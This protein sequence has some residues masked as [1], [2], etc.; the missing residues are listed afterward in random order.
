MTE[1]K[2]VAIVEIHEN[3]D[4]SFIG[5]WKTIDGTTKNVSEA[6]E[7]NRLADSI[8]FSV[9]LSAF[10]CDDVRVLPVKEANRLYEESKERRN[11]RV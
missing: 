2:E 4:V 9:A 1:A 7:F 10:R 11:G 8:G 5:T 3:G 6:I